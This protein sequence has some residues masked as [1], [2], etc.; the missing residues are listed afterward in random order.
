MR[1]IRSIIMLASLAL[2][3]ATLWLAYT[4]HTYGVPPNPTDLKEFV[5]RHGLNLIGD[6]LAG[7]LSL[8]TLLVVI[9]SFAQQSAQAKQTVKDMKAQNDLNAQIANANYKVMMFDRRLEL[10]SK[11]NRI[12][13][14][15]MQAGAMEPQTRYMFID[16]VEH[17]R[18]IFDGLLLEWLVDLSSK[19]HSAMSLEFKIGRLAKR[20]Q[21]GGRWSEEEET[22]YSDM[23]DEQGKIMEEIEGQLQPENLMAKLAGFLSL[24]PTIIASA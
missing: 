14:A 24:P 12:S 1:L 4:F 9:A 6:A 11:L 22:N 5:D 3:C 20:K 21:E 17:A 10:V 2:A 7:F 8:V 18:W 16:A 13:G 15:I 23:L 19:S